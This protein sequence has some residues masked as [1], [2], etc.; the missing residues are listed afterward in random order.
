MAQGVMADKF[1]LPAIIKICSNYKLSK[2]IGGVLIAVGISMTELTAALLSFQ[3][4]GV[5]MTEFGLALVIGGL[6]YSTTMIPVFA[7]LMNFGLLNKRPHE[8]QS[9]ENDF[10]TMRFKHCFIRDVTLSMCSLCLFFISLESGSIRIIDLILQ[11]TLF[12][13]YC[14]AVYIQDKKY[15]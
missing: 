11:L 10:I 6:A 8:T 5:K 4:H 14:V 15:S 7:Y 9:P 3:R 13:V 1:L 2:S 12:V